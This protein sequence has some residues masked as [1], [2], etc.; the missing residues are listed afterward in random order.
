MNRGSFA[1]GVV[2]SRAHRGYK[3]VDAVQLIGE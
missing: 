2:M 1:L 3:D